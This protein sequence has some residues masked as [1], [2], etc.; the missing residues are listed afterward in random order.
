MAI[1]RCKASQTYCQTR[2]KQSL[3]LAGVALRG[4]CERRKSKDNCHITTHIHQ[5]SRAGPECTIQ[6]F[7]WPNRFFAEIQ[8]GAPPPFLVAIP[9]ACEG[10]AFPLVL[11]SWVPH[12]PILRVGLEPNPER[13]LSGK[14]PS[15]VVRCHPDRTRGPQHA[16]SCVRWGGVAKDPSSSFFLRRSPIVVIPSACEGSAFPLVLCSAGLQPRISQFPPC[17]SIY[18]G[19][20]LTF[21]TCTTLGQRRSLVD[22]PFALRGHGKIRIAPFEYYNA[23]IQNPIDNQMIMWYS[24]AKLTDRG[25][26]SG[27]LCRV[28]KVFVRN[29]SSPF[30][31][32]PPRNP[33]SRNSQNARKGRKMNTCTEIGCNSRRM[34]TYAIAQITRLAE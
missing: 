1:P 14:T 2:E 12:T 11:C 5:V 24:A 18:A 21:R 32:I 7:D 33:I 23:N 28:T 10:S 17:S 29:T 25:T 8:R 6:N 13:P 26:Q 22:V 27:N 19:G 15:P 30:A 4:G 20:A 9:S 31:L 3:D 34:N 16:R